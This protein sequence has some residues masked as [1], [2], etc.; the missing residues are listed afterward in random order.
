MARRRIT[1]TCLISI[2]A[3]AVP[4]L[5]TQVRAVNNHLVVDSVVV[6]WVVYRGLVETL[7]DDEKV[8]NRRSPNP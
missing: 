1:T 3:V 6:R 8:V 2:L 5:N 7:A 4:G